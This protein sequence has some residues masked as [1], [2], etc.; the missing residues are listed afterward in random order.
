MPLVAGALSLVFYVVGLTLVARKENQNRFEG[1]AALVLLSTPVA[2][3]VYARSDSWIAWA[4][5]AAFVI[6]VIATLRPLLSESGPGVVPR[7][8][9]RMIAGICLLDGMLGTA[10]ATWMFAAAGI[11]GLGSTLALQRFV[12]GT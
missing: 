11:G 3:A 4:A 12:R 8:V 9:V 10:Y 6:W 2:V 7:A 5:L 1:R